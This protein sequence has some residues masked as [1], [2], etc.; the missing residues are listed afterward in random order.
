MQM[1]ADKTE[2]QMNADVFYLHSSA[3]ICGSTSFSAFIG[4]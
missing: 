3:F 2:L 1:N 4:G